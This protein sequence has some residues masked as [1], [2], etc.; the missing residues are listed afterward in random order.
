M[1]ARPEAGATADH[2]CGSRMDSQP[3]GTVTFLF[4]DIEGSTTAWDT[5]HQAMTVAQARHDEIL[6]EAIVEHG[7]HV[8]ATGGDGVAAAFHTARAA[9]EAAVA[10]QVAFETEVWPPPLKLRVRMGVHTGEAVE[11]GGDYFGPA[12]IKAA[13]LMSLVDGGR[14]A[15]SSTTADVVKPHL[16]ADVGLLPVGTV[17]LKGLGATEAVWVVTAP[18]LDET[19]AQL[20]AA[21]PALRRVPAPATPLVGRSAEL[22]ACVDALGSHRLVT[23]VGI[24]GIGKTRL[25]QAVTERRPDSKE[26]SDCSPTGSCPPNATAPSKVSSTGRTR[27][28]PA[29]HAPHS[30]DCRARSPTP[31]G[32]ARAP[33]SHEPR[34]TPRVPRCLCR[35]GRG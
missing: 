7:G 35:P 15:T 8:F 34:S 19:G 33:P 16:A 24:G 12:V 32:R 14:I 10:A 3:T 30:G 21:A 22:D 5:E 18:G 1:T 29:R 11:R 4:T 28:S 20:A 27:R 2:Y 25:A 23:V 26:R 17:R 31:A 9:T 6:R 13:R